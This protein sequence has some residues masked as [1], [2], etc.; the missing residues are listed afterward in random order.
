MLSPYSWV[1]WTVWVFSI[2]LLPVFPNTCHQ[3][4]YWLVGWC[5]N[6]NKWWQF[7]QQFPTL[8]LASW[9]HAGGDPNVALEAL[10]S[11]KAQNISQ[12]KQKVQKYLN[13]AD[14]NSKYFY[15]CLFQCKL[16]NKNWI[17][18]L[19]FFT[20]SACFL[21]DVICQLLD[22]PK[23]ISTVW[24]VVDQQPLV[25]N[26]DMAIHEF[27]LLCFVCVLV[28]LIS[29]QWKFFLSIFNFLFT[30]HS[31]YTINYLFVLNN[32]LSHFLLQLNSLNLFRWNRNERCLL[33]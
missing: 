9:S 22:D 23:W 30:I 19:E 28:H 13:S 26:V 1:F 18:N 12:S 11:R 21:F 25:E 24:A 31:H 17:F 32:I 29:L 5:E 8:T 7:Q 6:W 14:G 2:S 4:K 15:H 10:L 20:S 16:D 3:W 33:F 27:Y